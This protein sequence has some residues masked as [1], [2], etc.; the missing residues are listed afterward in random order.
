MRL[1]GVGCGRR[2]EEQE[3]PLLRAR[4]EAVGFLCLPQPLLRP[5][6]HAITCK[7]CRAASACGKL[8]PDMC[9]QESQTCACKRVSSKRVSSNSD[10]HGGAQTFCEKCCSR[11][12][13]RPTRFKSQDDADA[14][15]WRCPICTRFT[16]SLLLLRP[17]TAFPASPDTAP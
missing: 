13:A 12:L 16:L 4:A 6:V 10:C 2:A 8:C 11:H 7:F 3:L 9:L 15:D 5:G 14:A 1:W 17:A